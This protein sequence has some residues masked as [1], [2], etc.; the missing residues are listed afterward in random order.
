MAA[1]QQGRTAVAERVVVA[2]SAG[3]LRAGDDARFL[4]E[5]P[6]VGQ[7]AAVA[8][9]VGPAEAHVL[10]MSAARTVTG[11][12]ST[13]LRRARMRSA[14]RLTWAES[15]MV[16]VPLVAMHMR[17]V[18]ASA[19]ANAQQQPQLLR[20][21]TVLR[22]HTHTH[23]HRECRQH[24]AHRHLWSRMS[25]MVTAHCGQL[26]AESNEAVEPDAHISKYAS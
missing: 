25:P 4:D 21:L 16:S 10:P 15:G 1:S 17:S 5:V 26:V 12:P 6:S 22:A 8:A 3:L 7:H 11:P 18:A 13:V 23:T 2:E 24:W 14:V 20:T 19:A 9:R